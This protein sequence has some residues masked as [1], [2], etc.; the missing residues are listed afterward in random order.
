MTASDRTEWAKFRTKYLK[1]GPTLSSIANKASLAEVESA[2]FVVAL[3]DRPF[4]YDEVRTTL[5]ST[6]S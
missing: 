4:F 3:D 2:A 5:N 1:S 6:Q